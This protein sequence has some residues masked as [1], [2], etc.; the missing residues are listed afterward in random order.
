MESVIAVCSSTV[1]HH[2][3]DTTNKLYFRSLA[4]NRSALSRTWHTTNVRKR[5]NRNQ[6]T[7]F[8]SHV[9]CAD[10]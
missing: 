10:R 5:A 2:K 7:P 3:C 8:T 1:D 6:L 9:R 4:H